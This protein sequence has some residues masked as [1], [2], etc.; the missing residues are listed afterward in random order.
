[1]HI[2]KHGR[3]DEQE[4]TVGHRS[5]LPDLIA[6]HQDAR[7]ARATIERLSRAG[8]DGGA[9]SL[10]AGREVVTA[11]RYGD[12]Q[13]DRGSSLV[14]G[15]RVL[16]GLAWGVVPGALFGVVLLATSTESSPRVLLAGAGGGALLGASIGVLL[17]L[18]TV[19]TM[20]SSWERTFAPM[21]PGGVSIGVRID[22][23]RT[24][25]RAWPILRSSGADRLLQVADLDDL[26]PLPPGQ[27][28]DYPTDEGG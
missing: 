16:R 10:L 21:V 5:G 15:G 19:P 14:L 25:R 22:R 4:P 18:L 26:P 20:A 28:P 13:I 3:R 12:R 7:A 11:G 1:V 23:P 9:I 2:R 24:M 27:E 6:V 8:I 17:S